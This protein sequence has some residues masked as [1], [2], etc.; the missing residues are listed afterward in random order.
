MLVKKSGKRL[1]SKT[2]AKK[3]ASKITKGREFALLLS[4]IQAKACEMTVQ[5]TGFFICYEGGGGCLGFRVD[6]AV[7]QLS[8]LW[9]GA[10]GWWG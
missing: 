1:G 5:V 7:D 2:Q 4:L 6:G 9:R 3:E 10:G 8:Y